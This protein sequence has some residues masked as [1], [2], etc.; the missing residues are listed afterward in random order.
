[1]LHKNSNLEVYKTTALTF[2]ESINTDLQTDHD[3]AEADNV[4]KFC[5][6]AEKE[7]DNAKSS[8]LAQTASIDE[9]FKTVDFI[10]EELRKK[11][12]YLDKLAKSKKESVK[13]DIINQATAKF[14]EFISEIN[15]E[16]TPVYLPQIQADFS[17]VTKN[18]RTISSLH[19]SVDSE[20]AR[21]KIEANDIAQLIRA[22]I[23]FI[24]DTASDYKFLFNDTQQII[25]KYI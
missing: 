20:L 19:D 15:A 25:I 14:N 16:F 11:R 18:K 17:G 22:N 7:L 6:K 23:A 12:L 4:V 9:L 3:F 8:A 1:M 13:L 24:R 10:K 2:I 5:K 21:V